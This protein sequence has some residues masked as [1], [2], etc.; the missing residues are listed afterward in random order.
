MINIP[1]FII[2]F[3][4]SFIFLLISSNLIIKGLSDY[5]QKL[6]ISKYIN[7]LLIVTLA[8]SIP[9]LFTA[10][11][12]AHLKFE[13]A[14]LLI[15]IGTNIAHLF[16]VFGTILI[17]AKKLNIENH[18]L[19][20]S[21]L[22][23][24]ILSLMPFIMMLDK[25]LS[26]PDGLLL[27]AFYIIYLIFLVTKEQ[28]EFGQVKKQILIKKIYKDFIIITGSLFV[29]MISAYLLTQ[30]SI[31]ISQTK[32]L[33]FLFIAATLIPIGNSI[34]DLI[35]SMR[36]IKKNKKLSL[37]DILGS[38]MTNYLLSLGILAIIFP[39]NIE[40]TP[41]LVLASFSII[42]MISFLISIKS[43]KINYKI[44]IIHILF[45]FL[46]LVIMRSIL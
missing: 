2:I 44:G 3:I 25:N 40:H 7:G 5:A 1:L 18:F 33:S 29:L 28:G 42:G 36:Y 41:L 17:Y 27:I 16:F 38:T 34:A 26:R 43:K 39:I 23:L 24:F 13:F 30:S 10:I 22:F 4:T 20:K 37:A 45:Y 32:N 31:N 9:E 15:L 12:A 21:K 19:H 35:V 46:Y 14:A 6:K 8:A 11:S